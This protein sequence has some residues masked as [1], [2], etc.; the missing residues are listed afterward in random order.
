M[1]TKGNKK[2]ESKKLNKNKIAKSITPLIAI[3][4]FIY[5]IYKVIKLIIVPTDVYMIENGTIYNEED[6]V[7]L[8]NKR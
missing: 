2:V 1:A 7:R 6:A 4:I 5:I 3:I 8:C